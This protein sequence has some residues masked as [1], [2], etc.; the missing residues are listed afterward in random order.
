VNLG[1]AKSLIV[2]IAATVLGR[3]IGRWTQRIRWLAILAALTWI[4]MLV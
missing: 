2:I 3:A 4:G 1:A